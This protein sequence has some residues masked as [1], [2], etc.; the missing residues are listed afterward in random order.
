MQP[1]VVSVFISHETKRFDVQSFPSALFNSQIFSHFPQIA[2][3]KESESWIFAVWIWPTTDAEAL[4]RKKDRFQMLS[5]EFFLVASKHWA[6]FLLTA[7]LR[8]GLAPLVCL[9]VIC[10]CPT[11][12]KISSWWEYVLNWYEILFQD[13]FQLSVQYI[14]LSHSTSKD[15]RAVNLIPPSSFY[16][17]TR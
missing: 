13:C 5:L 10:H 1:I 17:H 6:W 7:L 15:L 12:V 4:E 9:S 11:S 8:L 3:N 16:P 2:K 14:F